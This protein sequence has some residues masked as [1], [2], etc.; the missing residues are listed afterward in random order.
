MTRDPVR[1]WPRLFDAAGRHVCDEVR[2]RV[3]HF[4]ALQILRNL[5]DATV[6]RLCLAARQ[7]R[8]KPPGDADLGHGGGFYHFDHRSRLQ[9]GKI[10]RRLFDFG[11]GNP[12]RRLDHQLRRDSL[13]DRGRPRAAFEVGHLLYDVLCR[14]TGNAGIFPSKLGAIFTNPP[15][16]GIWLV[17]PCCRPSSHEA[18]QNATAARKSPS[19]NRGG[20]AMFRAAMAYSTAPPP[21]D[22]LITPTRSACT[23]GC[24]CRNGSAP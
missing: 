9:P 13:R 18:G 24:G 21:C 17:Q 5:D 23:K 4:K 12:L 19:G 10:G 11:I 2:S 1:A 8:H 3:A 6:D 14:K 16:R 15:K 20:R 22:Q 7:R